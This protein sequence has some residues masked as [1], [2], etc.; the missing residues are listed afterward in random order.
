MQYKIKETCSCGAVLEFEENVQDTLIQSRIRS[1]QENFH[2][3][4]QECRKPIITG[5]LVKPKP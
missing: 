4:H 1:I 2:K 5:K 3:E